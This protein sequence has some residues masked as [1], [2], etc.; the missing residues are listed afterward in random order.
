M[1]V[2]VFVMLIAGV[3][4]LLWHD[5]FLIFAILFVT[6]LLLGLIKI[7]TLFNGDTG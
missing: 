6:C 7:V 4:V 3:L 2:L 1:V 5:I